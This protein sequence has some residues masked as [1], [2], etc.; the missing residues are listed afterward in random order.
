MSSRP[1]KLRRDVRTHFLRRLK[2]R[3]GIELTVQECKALERCGTGCFLHRDSLSRTWYLVKIDEQWVYCLY[4]KNL[5]F[6]TVLTA[7]HFWLSHPDL[8]LPIYRA[9]SKFADAW[10][11]ARADQKNYKPKHKPVQS[12]IDTRRSPIC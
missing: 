9:D 7:E 2:E 5:G 11:A 10:L 8:I 6:T 1:P 12:L 3:Y 4:Q